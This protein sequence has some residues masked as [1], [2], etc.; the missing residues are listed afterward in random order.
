MSCLNP[1]R[2]HGIVRLSY[3]I[4]EAYCPSHYVCLW[5]SGETVRSMRNSLKAVS[6]L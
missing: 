4:D 3:C 6:Y 5:Y 2:V 1:L